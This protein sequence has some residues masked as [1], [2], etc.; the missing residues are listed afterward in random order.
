MPVVLRILEGVV[1]AR[2]KKRG[3]WVRVF[4]LKEYCPQ[5]GK[6]DD[7]QVHLCPKPGKTG[8][9]ADR[10]VHCLTLGITVTQ[11]CRTGV[12][13]QKPIEKDEE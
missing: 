11:D 12:I 5:C 6:T 13:T 2:E 1:W 3:T 7:H 8:K 10:I 9:G 4:T